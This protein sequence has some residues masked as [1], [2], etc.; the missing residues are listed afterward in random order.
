[1]A[2]SSTRLGLRATH[3][4]LLT[5]SVGCAFAAG[6]QQM[7]L[8]ARHASALQQTAVDPGVRMIVV[9]WMVEVAEEFRLQQETLHA[10]VLL[11]DRFMANSEVT[12]RGPYPSWSRPAQHVTT[13]QATLT[14]CV[15]M[16]RTCHAV[17]CSCWPSAASCWHQRSWK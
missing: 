7:L 14:V 16:C 8:E 4:A 9:S 12:D 6:R 11:L 17:C 13:V 1:M 2:A 10:A 15:V 5:A 3:L